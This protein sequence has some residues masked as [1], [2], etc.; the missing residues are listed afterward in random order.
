MDGQIEAIKWPQNN[1]YH[2]SDSA[3]AALSNASDGLQDQQ[4]LV[5]IFSNLSWTS[6]I[7]SKYSNF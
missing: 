6:R 5:H 2:L 1:G 7:L 3:A 4:I